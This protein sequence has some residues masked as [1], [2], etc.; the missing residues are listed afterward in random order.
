MFANSLTSLSASCGLQGVISDKIGSNLGVT[1]VLT[2]LW[3]NLA[4]LPMT[5]W[6]RNK[7]R[8]QVSHA[9]CFLSLHVLSY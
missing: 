8:D 4:G 2:S 9:A 3:V 7:K 6:K 1:V 5:L